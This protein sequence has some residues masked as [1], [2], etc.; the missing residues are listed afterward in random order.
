VFKRMSILL[1]LP[2]DDRATF[3][4]KWQH[5]GTLVSRMPLIRSYLQNHVV[6][7]FADN[8]PIEA[9]GIVELRF[10][11]PEDMP[12]AF[13]SDAAVP[14]RA[15]EPNFLGHGTGYGIKQDSQSLKS[16]EGAKII[17][18]IAGSADSQLTAKLLESVRSIL[19]L[20]EVVRDDVASIIGR[21][22]MKRE[23]QQVSSF[24]HLLF[25]DSQTASKAG[26]ALQADLVERGK[27]GCL[28]VHRVQTLAVI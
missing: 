17:I 6:E 16:P 27:G 2:Q 10:D 3:A 13:A 15:D 18:S 1:R 5:H 25:E 14:V 12:A 11:K 24:L 20:R 21:P 28:T 26:Q 7:E 4:Q 8:Q 22:E 23:P 19:G 9:D